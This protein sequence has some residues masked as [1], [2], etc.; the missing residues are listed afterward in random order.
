[1]TIVQIKG[2]T[3]VKKI[4]LIFSGFILLG[5]SHSI[6]FAEEE[7]AAEK[8]KQTHEL[9]SS[10]V[11]YSQEETKA[12]YYQNLEIIDLLKQIRT[13]LDERLKEPKDSK[14]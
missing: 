5:L 2:Q 1:M 14:G 3:M 7:T 10:D 9:A 12:L 13:L 8:A 4:S 11:I 6:V